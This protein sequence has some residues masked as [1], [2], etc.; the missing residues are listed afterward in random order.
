MK[1]RQHA[2]GAGSDAGKDLYISAGGNWNICVA[3]WHLSGCCVCWKIQH[4]LRP[5][6]FATTQSTL[7]AEMYDEQLLIA[8]DETTTVKRL[9]FYRFC[10]LSSTGRSHRSFKD[11][12]GPLAPVELERRFQPITGIDTWRK[13]RRYPG[14]I[15]QISHYPSSRN[16][17]AVPPG[18]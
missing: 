17:C 18:S 2:I 6:L 5:S 8:S 12:V 13:S 1:P 10:V 15:R 7:P 11:T 4:V 16:T 3:Q 14:L 9:P